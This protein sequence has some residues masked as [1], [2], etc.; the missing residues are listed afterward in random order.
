MFS[1]T[2]R[3]VGPTLFNTMNP[4]PFTGGPFTIS[5][6]HHFPLLDRECVYSKKTRLKHTHT[7]LFRKL[8]RKLCYTTPVPS[9]I[10]EY[11]LTQEMWISGYL[12]NIKQHK[13]FHE[14]PQELP[15]LSAGVLR[16]TWCN[17][18][19]EGYCGND[20][21]VCEECCS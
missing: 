3:F 16:G 17:W 10:E 18:V 5:L 15:Q 11:P 8:R 21:F 12:L 20:D 4:G 14:R 6:R 13:H 19:V 1:Q 2:H 9:A 7:L